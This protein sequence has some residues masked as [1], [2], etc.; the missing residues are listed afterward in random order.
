MVVS[1]DS[2]A[3]EAVHVADVGFV[4][5]LDLVGWGDGVGPSGPHPALLCRSIRG[6]GKKLCNTVLAA[7]V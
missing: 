4:V 5:D 6:L 1:A 7:T 3:V 2:T